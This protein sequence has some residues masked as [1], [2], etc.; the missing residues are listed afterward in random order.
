MRSVFLSKIIWCSASARTYV[1]PIVKSQQAFYRSE[2]DI[3]AS[4]MDTRKQVGQAKEHFAAIRKKDR[5]E[6]AVTTVTVQ[7]KG[8]EMSQILQALNWHL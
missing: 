2:S 5:L 3:V 7:C 1:V 4:G 8:R 6:G